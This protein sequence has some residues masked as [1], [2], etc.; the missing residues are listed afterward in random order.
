MIPRISLMYA[1]SACGSI[2]AW[3]FVSA[4]SSKLREYL[5]GFDPTSVSGKVELLWLGGLLWLFG[6]IHESGFGFLIDGG[7]YNTPTSIPDSG[8]SSRQ[9]GVEFIGLSVKE[10]KLNPPRSGA[11]VHNA[12]IGAPRFRDRGLRGHLRQR[13]DTACAASLPASLGSRHESGWFHR[14]E[15]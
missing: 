2:S 10:S 6:R 5:Y 14:H 1:L 4:V 9:L 3:G 7:S 12:S 11:E 13:T 8:H 15:E